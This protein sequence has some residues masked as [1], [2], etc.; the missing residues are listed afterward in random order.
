MDDPEWRSG[1]ADDAG[2]FAAQLAKASGAR[3]VRNLRVGRV[4]GTRSH[5]CTTAFCW[6]TNLDTSA[7]PAT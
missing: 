2:S 7:T 3:R 1:A 5:G 6:T 4:A